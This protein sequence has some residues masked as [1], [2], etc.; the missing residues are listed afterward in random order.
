LTA[1]GGW[2]QVNGGKKRKVDQALEHQQMA[3]SSRCR[4]QADGLMRWGS[5]QANHQ[6]LSGGGGGRLALATATAGS[7]IV[8]TY[9]RA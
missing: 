5:R 3:T 1:E 6:G 7:I 4:L 8:I 9:R 2:S